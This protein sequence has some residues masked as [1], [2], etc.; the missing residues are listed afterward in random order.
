MC[1]IEK[2]VVAISVFKSG[3]WIIR[4]IIADLTNLKFVE[5]NIAGGFVDHGDPKYLFHK[6]GLFYSWHLVP[7]IPVQHKLRSMKAQLVIVL[8]NIYDLSVSMYYHFINNVDWEINRG[9]GQDKFFK[10]LSKE[11]GLTYI[12]SGSKEKE[13]YWP[14]IGYYMSQ[15]ELLLE[16]AETYPCC[17]LTFERLVQDRKAAV[18]DLARYLTIKI[19]DQRLA[20]VV[21]ASSFKSMKERCRQKGI[22]SHFRIGKAFAYG[23]DLNKRHITLLQT[24]MRQYAPKLEM[25]AH[26]QG[27]NEI[28]SL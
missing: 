25:L 28:I 11:R 15:M 17:V 22:F 19:D 24:Q 8:R 12:I 21:E 3:T 1:K 16:F 7:T 27:L 13:F 23:N 5:P 26:R 14:G 18:A 9:A 10:S 6:S 20:A 4:K 2:P